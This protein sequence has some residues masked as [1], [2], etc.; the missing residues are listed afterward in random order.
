[1]RVLFYGARPAGLV[2]LLTLSALGHKIV[3]VVPDKGDTVVGKTAE[4]LGFNVMR[5][6]SLNSNI[7]KIKELDLDLIVC[8]HGWEIF[9]K[10]LLDVPKKGSIN[11]HP[12]LFRFPG[13]HPVKRL[14]ESGEKKAS[15][16]AHFMTEKLDAGETIC[17][18]FTEIGDAKT[19]PEVYNLL[20]PLY[21]QCVAEALKKIKA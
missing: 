15:V 16:A 5:L 10:E 7:E 2:V 18:I 4:K 3:A 12:C 6:D 19:E 17:E 11:L 21:G 9:K 14:L 1:M 8:C 20:Y 13:L